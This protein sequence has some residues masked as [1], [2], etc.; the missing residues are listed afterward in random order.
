MRAARKKQHEASLA[1]VREVIAQWKQRPTRED[2][3]AWTVRKFNQR[4]DGRDLEPI[5]SKTLTRWVNRG[6][7]K[8]P[9]ADGKSR[10][11]EN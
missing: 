4:V 8:P 6:E 1:I 7:L 3:K 10:K 5:T 2:W 9:V 11:G